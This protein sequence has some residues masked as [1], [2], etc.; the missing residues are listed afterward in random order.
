MDVAENIPIEAENIFA[1]KEFAL[2]HKIDLT[3]VGPEGPLSNGI[4]DEFNSAGL[5]CFGPSKEAALIESSKSFTR[6]LLKKY[7]IPSAEYAVFSNPQDAISY[8]KKN[9]VPIVV[10][11]DGLA[12]GKGVVVCETE[13]Q[14]IDAIN[15]MLVEKA[16]GKS[17]SKIL[18][19]EKLE[20]EEAS[21][22]AFCDG[23]NVV[24][25]VS[26][27]DHKR[28]FDKDLGSNTGGMGAYSPAPIVSEKLMEKIVETILKPTVKAMALEG[29]TYKGVLYAGLMIDGE[30]VSVLEFNARFGD[31]ETQVVLPR[32]DSDLVLI[33]L[34]CI[35][36]KLN[37]ISIDWKKDAACCVVMA[38]GGYPGYYEKGK[39]ISGLNE[40][41]K[42]ENAMVFHAGTK[43][44]GE[45]IVSNGGRVLNVVGL[46]S[47]I[48][49]SI[50][51]AYNAV[52]KISFEKMHYRKDIGFRA[53]RKMKKGS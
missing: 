27:Q 53:L 26:S 24:P 20:G 16:F 1:L 6:G 50:D 4:V 12:A 41:K 15:S 11:A 13:K 2:K 5:K 21:I 18:L 7:G 14:A 35:E 9:G 8:V 51:A 23:K 44:I 34:A 33:M 30:K 39:K 48:K 22:L 43:K 49:N 45:D 37:G 17:S 28:V 19:E 32:L 29:R 38:S 10:K 25:M 46:G 36:G 52:S 47:T 42:L 3:V 40:V 31:P